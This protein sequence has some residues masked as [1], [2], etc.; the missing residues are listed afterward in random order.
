VIVCQIT[1]LFNG[2]EGLADVID[3]VVDMLCANT[4]ADG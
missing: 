3:D 4:Q 1:G 2:V